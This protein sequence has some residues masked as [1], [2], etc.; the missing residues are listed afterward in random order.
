MIASFVI[1]VGGMFLITEV[2]WLSYLFGIA[3]NWISVPAMNFGIYM[4]WVFHGRVQKN[5]IG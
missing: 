2:M 4:F 1:S 5:P 3:W